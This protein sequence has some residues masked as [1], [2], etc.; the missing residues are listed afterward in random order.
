MEQGYYNYT[1]SKSVH[2]CLSPSDLDTRPPSHSGVEAQTAGK[3]SVAPLS[4]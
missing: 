3:T 2:T 4:R 1:I